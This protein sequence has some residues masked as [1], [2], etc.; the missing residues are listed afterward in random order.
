MDLI[1]NGGIRRTLNNS[2][3]AAGFVTVET[4]SEF[5]GMHDF[6]ECREHLMELE[7]YEV[8]IRYFDY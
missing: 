7:W 2:I 8:E 4:L 5:G 3:Q 6:W 1:Q